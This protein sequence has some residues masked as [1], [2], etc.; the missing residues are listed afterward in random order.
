MGALLCLISAAC[1]GAMAIFGKLAYDAGVEV[2]DLLLVRFSLA[3]AAL[4]AIAGAADSISA[5]CRS[6][7]NQTTTPEALR[8][9]MSAIF[10]LV[11]T[12]G[13]RLGDVEAG[14]IAAVTSPR[15]SMSSGGLACI[16]GVVMAAFPALAAYDARN[17][18]LP[19]WA[20]AP[21]AADAR[22]DA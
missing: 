14:T 22:G 6:I 2:G 15:I 1:F 21:A 17:T 9:R 10:M 11:V 5:V 13:P 3:A 16:V 8:G 12:S 19:T 4:L 20:G 7:I 18:T